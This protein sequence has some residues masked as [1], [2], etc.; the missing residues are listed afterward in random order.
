MRRLLWVLGISVSLLVLGSSTHALAQPVR[1]VEDSRHDVSAPLRDMAIPAQPSAGPIREMPEPGEPPLGEI[2]PKRPDP[3]AQRSFSPGSTPLNIPSLGL[4]FAGVGNIDSVYPPDT[5]GDVGPNHYVQWVNLHLQIWDKSGTTLL[6]PLAGNS[7]WSGF[8]APCSTRNDGDPVVLYDSIADRWVISQ[9]T[10]AS[11]WG[12]CVAVSTTADPTGAWYR[13]FFQFSTTAFYDYPHMAV[14][15]D[16]Y[17]MA[18][19][20][21]NAAGTSFLGAS[22]I[23]FDRARM[24]QG[25]SATFQEFQTSSAVGSMLPSDLDG[26]LLPPAGSPNYFAVRNT[27]T[28]DIY[29]FHVDWTTPANSTFTGPTG[30]SVAPYNLLCPGTRS[31]IPQ[32]ATA[33]GLD[34]IGD[35]LIHRFAYRNFGDHE[36]FVATMSVDVDAT[37][38]IQAAPRWY[39]VRNTPPGGTMTLYQQGTYAPDT[40]NRWLP[41]V[42]MDGSGNMGIGY[43]Y[44]NGSNPA[45]IRYTGRL[46]GDPLDTM[47]QG[48]GTIQTGGGSQTGSA[49]RWGD[50]AMMAVDPSDD[51]TFWFTTEWMPST[52][53][54]PWQTRIAT[55]KFPTC[56]ACTPPSTPSV[57][58]D[59]AVCIGTPVTLTATAGYTSYQ[60]YKGASPIAGATSQTYNIPSPVAGDSGK[61]YVTG[62]LS[63]CTSQESGAFQL[64]VSSSPTAVA[65]GTAAICA[66]GSTS[67]SGSGG[68]SCSWSPATGLS[69]AASCTPSASP[70]STTTY[71]LTVTAAGGCASTN[72]PT[73]TVTVNSRPTAV[74]SGGT[75]ICAGGSTPLTGSGGVSCSWSPATGLSSA[76]SCTPTASPA[77]TTTYTLTVTSA[78]ACASTN[79]PTVTVTVNSPPSATVSGAATACALS[80][81]NTASVPVA[82]G[83]T[84]L[85]S[86]TGGTITAGQGTA[87]IAY[88]AGT[89][90][91]VSLGVTV[92]GSNGCAATG[93]KNVTISTAG[94]GN[95]YSLTPCRI[96]DTRNATG[97]YGAP[98]LSG[99]A[100]RTFVL[101]GQCAIPATAKA[102]S[103]NVTV[104]QPTLAGDLRLYAADVAA[105]NSSVINFR[106]GQTR[107]NNAVISLGASGDIVVLCDMP[108]PGTVQLILDVN[109]YFD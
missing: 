90:G 99:N 69:D 107:A 4:N 82:A 55:F 19:N 64:T 30:L 104:T 35:R 67:L 71:T 60:W 59:A 17:Y 9:F 87:A 28:L 10:S 109:G 65:G 92:T 13:Y 32:P 31:C 49:G 29:K 27:S 16:G 46:A 26:K 14:W 61:Y 98:P 43:S 80:Q 37:A 102:V 12:Q 23:V 1:V 36:S 15:P 38:V 51:C 7:I 47:P 22:A 40:V 101:G 94:C 74:A 62:T 6:G 2:P 3:V 11:P 24:L 5:N 88:T 93:S 84:Y 33:Q 8:G 86:I 53:T 57:S 95:F 45:G 66:G 56:S 106:P 105:P 34:G 75:A 50:Y 79:N 78:A 83:A 73:V 76:A 52:G 96:L 44:A 85:W 91:T 48:E 20:R 21:F 97:S 42:A 39:E 89:G 72:N 54:A 18:D 100:S 25:L 108:G 70:S 58:G 63:G 77:G 68:V 103:V 81:G 41:S